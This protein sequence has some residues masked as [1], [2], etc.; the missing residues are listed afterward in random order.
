MGKK[1]Q[2]AKPKRSAAEQAREDAARGENG[3]EEEPVVRLVA[4]HGKRVAVAVGNS[5]RVLDWSTGAELCSNT[6]HQRP[7]RALAFSADG[8]LLLTAGDDKQV[9]LWAT[10]SWTCVKT[11]LS[12]KKTSAAALTNDGRHVVF[13]DKFGDVCVGTTA[14]R[15]EG[16]QQQQQQQQGQQG[17]GQGQR[18]GGEPQ[19]PAPLLGHMQSIVTSA[20]V[21]PTDRLVVTTDRDAKA[22]VSVL[23]EDPLLGSYQIQAYC[24]GHREF[25]AA[26]AA[27]PPPPGGDASGPAG[28]ALLL[29]GGG[30]G[31][32]KLWDPVSGEQ[33]GSHAAVSEEQVAAATAAAAAAHGE[34]GGKDEADGGGEGGGGG[35]GEGEGDSGGSDAEGDGGGERDAADAAPRRKQRRALLPVVAVAVAPSGGLAAVVV[36][37]QR[38]V[39]LLRIDAASRA[40][41]PCV[42]RLALP[43]DLLAP[44]RAA[45]DERGRLW[46]VG[47]P[48][49]RLTQSAHVAVAAPAG[50]GAAAPFAFATDAALPAA[51]RAFLERRVEEEEAVAAEAAAA[52][53]TYTVQLRKRQYNPR[54][55]DSR[56]STRTDR[57]ES[58]RLARLRQR[59]AEAAA[60]AGAEAAAGEGAEA[61]A[62][63]AAA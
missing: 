46:L 48:P 14:P 6:D 39:Q 18:P 44:C 23:Q 59:E 27:V 28:G 2:A 21:L 51:A 35:D 42:Q 8:G 53:T 19:E 61:A 11:L 60:G 24:L 50:E 32:V 31:A 7:I 13:A 54:S 55:V 56:K 1:K 5:F 57:W 41:G 10:A 33:L 26:S 58:D 25:V 16:G 36:E 4:L 63:P 40:L 52:G 20:L 43:D 45:F 30:D 3:H 12:N 29:T 34:E 49:V 15:A 9:K 62:E 17:Q 22:R 47:G 37:G 38:E